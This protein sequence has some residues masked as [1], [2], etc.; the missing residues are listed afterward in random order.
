MKQR[1]RS[2]P[3]AL[4]VVP[5][6]YGEVADGRPEAPRCL[7]PGEAKVWKDVV[8][9][10]PAGWFGSETHV[11]LE[12][13][14]RLSIRSR[15]VAQSLERLKPTDEAYAKLVTLEG[16]LSRSL[17]NLATKMRLTQQAEFGKSM[18]LRKKQLQTSLWES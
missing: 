1:G 18:R 2:S 8:Q 9:A 5:F 6:N 16:K 12:C 4:S 17:T 14:C 15:K 7:T 3:A 10:M 11:L 13:Y